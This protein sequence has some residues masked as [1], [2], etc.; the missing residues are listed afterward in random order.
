MLE[1]KSLMM[2]VS[3]CQRRMNE[4]LICM[5]SGCLVEDVVEWMVCGGGSDVG[6]GG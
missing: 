4:C 5:I 6:V 2:V 1:V 3:S